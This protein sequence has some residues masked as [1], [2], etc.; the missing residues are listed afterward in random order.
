MRIVRGIALVVVGACVLGG[1]TRQLVVPAQAGST[2][3]K[4]NIIVI[5]A[6]D[7]GYGDTGVYGSPI[8]R[9]P[10]IDALASSGVRFTNGYV[11]HPVC[12]PSRAGLLTGRY[13][14]RFGYEFNGSDQT[15]GVSLNEIMLPK[16]LKEAGYVTGMVGKWHQGREGAYYPTARGFD[17]F[18][19]MAGGGTNYITDPKPGD[20][21]AG[22]GTDDEIN[23]DAPSAQNKTKTTKSVK[24][25][26]G[27]P[28]KNPP[29]KTAAKTSPKTTLAEQSGNADLDTLRE[30]LEAVRARAPITR[31]GVL[32]HEQEYLTDAMTR[33]GISFI[34]DHR[35]HPF[36]LYVAYHAP[37]TPLQVTKKYYDRFPE[38]ADKNTRIHAA[39]I[40]AMDDGVGA[41]EAT[42]KANGLDRNTLIFFLSDNGC[43]SYLHGACS[44]SS[45]VG[46]KRTH[47]EGGV[48]IPFILSW[49][50]HVA[51][52]QVD[53][54]TVSSLDLFPTAVAAAH[55]KLPSHRSYDGVDVM[56]FLTGAHS[57]T[58]NPVLYWRAG[59]TFAIRDHD[60]KMIVMNNAPPDAKAGNGAKSKKGSD[61][62]SVPP[63]SA[64]YGQHTMLYD[65]KASPTETINR[66]NQQPSVVT[67][68]KAELAAWNKLLVPPQRASKV[69]SYE[70]Y[71]GVLLHLYD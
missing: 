11:T 42:L 18:W 34:N 10:N 23:D 53:S 55:G 51:P 8:V 5:L 21:F 69:Q 32:I 7:L 38:I 17:S 31:N 16:T 43:P 62:S 41:L 56:P 63:Y 40:S 57:G 20:E 15:G 71:D 64:A 24:K 3:S 61:A 14:E 6:D 65:L 27:K 54:R 4:P 49:P 46:F 28:Q 26:V 67:R 59:P 70:T 48:R 19:G 36:F 25:G 66:A 1:S 60:W 35:G 2:V 12:A 50:G 33:E 29:G 13:Q 45:L 9:T 58:P 30:Q 37:H 44:N 22:I 68:L 39:M 52:G 47:F